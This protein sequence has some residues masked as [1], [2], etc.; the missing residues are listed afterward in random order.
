[1][2]AGLDPVIHAPNRL[3]MCCM[4]A[5][6]DTIDFATI[7]E[8]LDVSESVLS[9]HIKTLEETAYVTVRKTPLDGR[10]RT[11]VGLTAA[12]RKALKGHLAALKAMMA[13]AEGL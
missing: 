8:A 7:R 9:K 4:L 6:V 2:S 13:G 12:G 10:V 3:Q 11:W 5:A 1:M